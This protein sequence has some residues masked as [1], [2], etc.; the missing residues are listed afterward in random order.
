MA[1]R[2]VKKRKSRHPNF[3]RYIAA[4]KK[5]I[6]FCFGTRSSVNCKVERV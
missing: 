6:K 5:L 4:K 1:K 3:G 2:K